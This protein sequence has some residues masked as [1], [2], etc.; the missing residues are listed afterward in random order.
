MNACH[1]RVLCAVRLKFLR[2]ADHPSRGV[3]PHMVCLACDREA[4]TMRSLWPAR[5]CRAIQGGGGGSTYL[6]GNKCDCVSVLVISKSYN[7]ELLEFYSLLVRRHFSAALLT[8][9]ENRNCCDDVQCGREVPMFRSNLLSPSP[10]L[11]LKTV[12]VYV[13]SLGRLAGLAELEVGQRRGL[14]LPSEYTESCFQKIW[15]CDPQFSC[16]DLFF[17]YTACH[18]Q[19][20]TCMSNFQCISFCSRWRKS[21]K[22]MTLRTSEVTFLRS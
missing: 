6:G 7:G 12:V 10:G 1:L 15:T 4:S 3:L 19:R 21:N 18:C 16:R 14:S 9:S 20:L 22:E 17:F 2:R 11:C 13:F 5:V 8:Y